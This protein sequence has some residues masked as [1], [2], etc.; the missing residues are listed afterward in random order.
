MEIAVDVL[1][2]FLASVMVCV[3]GTWVW[4]ASLMRR[5]LA[6]TP[7]LDGFKNA[8][9]AGARVSVIL[10]AR[11]EESYIGRC[12][13]SLLDQDYAEYEIVVIDDSSTDRTGEIVAGYA[14]RDPRVVHVRAGP[15]PEGWMGKNWACVQGY[16]KATGSLLLFTD[17]DTRHSRRAIS[18]AVG[19]LDSS[20]LDALTASPRMLCL[21]FWTRV[22]LPVMSTFLHT[23]FSALRVNDQSSKTGYFF[24]SFFIIRRE[25]YEAV[26]THRS[27]KHE[28]IEDGVLGSR[29]KGSGHRVKMVRGEHV[30]DAVW[31]RDA[32]SLWNA[33][34][35]L[36]VPLYLQG[37]LVAA[38]IVTAVAFLLFLPFP[39]LAY[40]AAHAV[41]A[42]A[43][44][45]PVMLLLASLASSILVCACS[46]METRHMGIG[47]RYGAM[48]PLGGL[49]M[50]LG[51]LGGMIRA[52]GRASV[53]WR[54]RDYS[55]KDYVRTSVRV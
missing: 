30:V 3:A 46:I 22:T 36:I 50:L 48:A 10:P 18:L 19:H 15:K 23:R 9:G 4:L 41:P 2:Y 17:A 35:R 21:D 47:A 14:G 5:S 27:V 34:K 1:H 11:N 43:G 25:T 42:Y 53:S 7:R 39:I 44:P 28:I 55:M 54:G 24:G 40:S 45:G 26:G 37:R 16:S 31:A 49:V 38:G 12:L 20:G 29:V 6:K 8:G 33:I 13:D 52:G 51:F 32:S